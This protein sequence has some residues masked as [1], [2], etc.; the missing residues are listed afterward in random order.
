LE[1]VF[2]R[3]FIG[4]GVPDEHAIKLATE[5]RKVFP[6]VERWHLY[7]DS[8]AALQQ[9]SRDGW[10]HVILSNHVP[11][12][13]RI[14]EHLGVMNLFDRVYNSADTGVEKP[15]PKAFANVLASFEHGASAW[16][17]GDNLSVDVHGAVAA[18]I[19]AI[20]ARQTYAQFENQCVNLCEIAQILASQ[21]ERRFLAPER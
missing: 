19:P 5:V 11:E 20:L 2:E 12:L 15:H 21:K 16:M 6:D 7:D 10:T 14:L 1:P 8:L 9:L 17:I 13:T 18:G 4:V 3:A